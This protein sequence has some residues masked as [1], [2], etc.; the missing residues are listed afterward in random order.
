[1]TVATDTDLAKILCVDD[2]QN[3]IDA[4]KRN[5]FENYDVTTAPSGREGLEILANDGPFAVVVSDMQMP[6]MDGAAFLRQVKE[7]VPDTVRILLT[8]H[9]DIN[10]TLAAVNQ[11]NIFR[12]ICKPCHKEDLISALEDAVEFHRSITAEHDLLEKTLHGTAQVFV[13]ILG[14]AA[15]TAF[16]RANL[17][18]KY[19]THMVDHLELPNRWQYGLAAMLSQI[20]AITLPPNTLDKYYA[21]Q[22]VSASEQK[23]LDDLPETGARLLEAI[24][25]FAPVAAIIRRQK[26]EK[27][28]CHPA[29]EVQTGAAMLRLALE[30]DRR[31]LGGE[32]FQD[33]LF[34]LRKEKAQTY[35]PHLLETLKEY[36][37]NEQLDVIKSVAVT[38]LTCFMVLD[39]DVKTVDG[40]V[41]VAKGR[42]IT[43]TLRERLENFSSSVGI[44]EPIRVRIPG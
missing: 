29:D 18:R 41:I 44:L 15:P 10:A 11:G 27:T 1:M 13:D 34:V 2:E 21:K 3:V 25:R 37:C 19:V 9:A 5:L 28:R 23:M 38:E 39:E 32:R 42:E 31:V 43:P 6:E 7:M 36:R 4:L 14:L 17:V 8:G 35:D 20:G 26:D 24:P 12:F 40:H 30:L 16:S 33:A 22:A